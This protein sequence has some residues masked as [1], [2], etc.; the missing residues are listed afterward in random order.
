MK[1]GIFATSAENKH[2]TQRLLNYFQQKI[3]VSAI[4]Y[5]SLG[6][7]KLVSLVRVRLDSLGTSHHDTGYA[8]N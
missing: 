1:T 6:Y 8:S 3:C 5:V 2:T 4:G 7:S